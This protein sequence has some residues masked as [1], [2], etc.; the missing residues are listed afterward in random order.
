M[1]SLRDIGRVVF[2][3]GWRDPLEWARAVDELADL[4]D[5][6]I[7]RLVENARQDRLA[8]AAQ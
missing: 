4:S 6:E 2:R 3:H 7:E 5:D 1:A 8:G